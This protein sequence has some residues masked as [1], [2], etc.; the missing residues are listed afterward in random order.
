V[1]EWGLGI[2]RMSNRSNERDRLAASPSRFVQPAR[3]LV[4]GCGYVGSELAAQLNRHGHAVWALRRRSELLPSGLTG[5]AADLTDP[6]ALRDLPPKLDYVFYTA[7]ASERT[8]QGYREAYVDGLANLLTALEQQRHPIRRVLFTSSTAVYAQ[9]SGEWVDESSPTEPTAF[10]G[11]RMLEAEH[12]LLAGPFP[13]VVLRSAGIYGPG[14]TRMIDRVRNGE[15]ILTPGGP[16]YSNRIHRDDVAAALAHL[17]C[18]PEADR[19][20]IGADNEPADVA[21]VYR[22]LADALGLPSP[23]VGTS[24]T[25][26]SPRSNKRCRNRKLLA[27]GFTLR[28]PTF[29]EGYTALLADALHRR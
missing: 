1:G 29:R 15:A 9:C 19:V 17:M 3:I 23:P 16:R 18:L 5:I 25:E 27:T 21:D 6:A 22:W 14:R 2:V 7:A 4:A 11:T 26:E 20:Y 10:S 28:Y 12:L 24:T 8:D 13:V